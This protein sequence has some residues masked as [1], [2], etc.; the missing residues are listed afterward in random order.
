MVCGTNDLPLTHNVVSTV[1]AGGILGK[2]GAVPIVPIIR[3]RSA[4]GIVVGFSTVREH[5]HAC[6]VG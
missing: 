4:V 2:G 6:A 3:D 5:V 1:I